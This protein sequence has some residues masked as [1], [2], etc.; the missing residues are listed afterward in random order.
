[1]ISEIKSL[2]TINGPLLFFG[3]PYSNLEATLALKE[4]AESLGLPSQS[5]I[6]TG[7][8]LAYCGSPYETL[9][10]IRDWGVHVVRGNCEISFGSDAP[11]CGCGFAEGSVCSALSAGWYRFAQSKINREQKEWMISCPERIELDI[12][13][14]SVAV[15]H[16]GVNVT[17]RFIFPS[18]PDSIKQDELNMA[19][20]DI[21]IG[22]H[23]GIP[24]GTILGDKAWFNTGVIGMPANDGTRDGWYMLLSEEPS[25]HL[26]A[27]WHRLVYDA[28]KAAKAMQDNGLCGGYDK[29]LL[30]GIWPSMDIL[31]QEEID[32]QGIFLKPGEIILDDK[33]P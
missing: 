22:G 7:D 4:V 31:P 13:H 27:T 29:T 23:C 1:M 3:G 21:V 25:G 18:T 20:T 26:K 9:E 16:S 11:D 32:R 19:N 5:I 17:N 10:L 24:S 12:G 6:C 28:G 15:V 8:V 14:R 33:T 2:G 30:N